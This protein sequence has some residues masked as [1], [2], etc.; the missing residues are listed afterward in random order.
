VC[1]GSVFVSVQGHLQSDCRLSTK[2]KALHVAQFWIW[3]DKCY[4]SGT[5]WSV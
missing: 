1:A 2:Q 4:R 5:W 3:L